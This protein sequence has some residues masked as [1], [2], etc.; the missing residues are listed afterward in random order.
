MFDKLVSDILQERGFVKVKSID[1]TA[2]NGNA[3]NVLDE[4]YSAINS[5]VTYALDR[6][7]NNAWANLVYLIKVLHVA[8]AY[9]KMPRWSEFLAK[10]QVG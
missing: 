4:G 8:P 2:L 10:F 5:Y 3:Y 7:P 1:P 9:S 6:D